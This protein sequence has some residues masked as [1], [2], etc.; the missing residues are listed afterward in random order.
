[1]LNIFFQVYM[2]VVSSSTE[3]EDGRDSVE[4]YF[5]PEG[6]ESVAG[7]M[8]RDGF[9]VA[10]ADALAGHQS[11]EAEEFGTKTC[12]GGSDFDDG[13]SPQSGMGSCT[14][15]ALWNGM[16]NSDGNKIRTKRRSLM[17]FVTSSLAHL[18]ACE[19]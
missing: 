19:P 11:S 10:H 16:G 6:R 8:V 4:L 18:E 9:Y 3:S 13:D 1:M 15:N 12:E 7:R 5:D 2:K 17:D 14:S